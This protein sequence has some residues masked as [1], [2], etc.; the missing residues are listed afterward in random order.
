MENDISSGDF[1]DFPVY[2]LEDVNDI[3]NH[4]KGRNQKKLL[5]VFDAKDNQP[6][7]V[8]FLKKILGAAKFN[9][10]DDILLLSITNKKP[11]S[12][13]ALKTKIMDSLGDIDNF[14]AFGF[15]PDFFGLNIDGQKYEPIHFYNCGFLFSDSLSNLENDKKLKGALWQGM[16]KLFSL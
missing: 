3:L 7:K 16:Q 11:F 8:E 12:F 1:L 4:C 15:S 2:P 13:I 6:K 9:F 10:E 5:V 14:L